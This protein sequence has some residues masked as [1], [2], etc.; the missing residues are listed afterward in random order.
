[1]RHKGLAEG[2]CLPRKARQESKMKK[3]EMSREER[4]LNAKRRG[5]NYLKEYFGITF[6]AY[7]KYL[8]D[9]HS[10]KPRP[11]VWMIV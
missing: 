8:E 3:S 7:C 10:G 1:M 11:A 9:L 2:K 4:M 6:E 5:W